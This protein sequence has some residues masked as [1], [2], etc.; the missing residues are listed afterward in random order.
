MNELRG[1]LS[2][3]CKIGYLIFLEVQYNYLVEHWRKKPYHFLAD[4]ESMCVNVHA[5]LEMV[6]ESMRDLFKYPQFKTNPIILL[7][8]QLVQAVKG[9]C[10]SALIREHLFSLFGEKSLFSTHFSFN[11]TLSFGEVGKKKLFYVCS[12]ASSQAY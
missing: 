5:S 8:L 2:E 11:F 7:S 6:S 3:F 4:G 1:R 9:M 10:V 12:G